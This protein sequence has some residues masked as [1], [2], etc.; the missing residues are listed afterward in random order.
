MSSSTLGKVAL[1]GVRKRGLGSS[2]T[3]LK[4]K[5]QKT[6]LYASRGWESTD[7]V[8]QVQR[9]PDFKRFPRERVRERPWTPD[10]ALP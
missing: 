4:Q 1:S 7:G 8:K 5:L 2:P 3:P 9:T 6:P 10:G